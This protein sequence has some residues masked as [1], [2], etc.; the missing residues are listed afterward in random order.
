M[1]EEKARVLAMPGTH[2][3]RDRRRYLPAP[4]RLFFVACLGVLVAVLASYL[5]RKM[6]L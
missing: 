3:M 2:A 6:G 4:V 1:A 5:L